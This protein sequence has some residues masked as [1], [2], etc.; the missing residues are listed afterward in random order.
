M[1]IHSE[2]SIIRNKTNDDEACDQQLEVE[3][4][5]PICTFGKV[6]NG[7][8]QFTIE[9]LDEAIV[10]TAV[11][12]GMASESSDDTYYIDWNMHV[13]ISSLTSLSNNNGNENENE[14]F[15]W[16]KFTKCVWPKTDDN[17]Y[18]IK[19]PLYLQSYYVL[20]KIQVQHKKKLHYISQR[21]KIHRIKIESFLIHPK[22]EVGELIQYRVKNAAYVQD[23]RI[24]QILKND[25]SGFEYEIE[26][27]YNY[28]GDGKNKYK[29]NRN[30]I[31]QDSKYLEY[32]I[33][34]CV[35]L[36][37]NWMNKHRFNAECDLILQTR[38]KELRNYYW[39]LR[40]IIASI[41][42]ITFN[43]DSQ[44]T[45]AYLYNFEFIGALL[46]QIITNYLYFDEMY[47]NKRDKDSIINYK[48][49]CFITLSHPRRTNDGYDVGYMFMQNQ[50][51]MQIDHAIAVIQQGRDHASLQGFNSSGWSCDLCRCTINVN[52]WMYHCISRRSEASDT[53]GHAYCLQCTYSMTNGI[54]AFENSLQKIIH[55]YVDQQ[56]TM[57]CIKVIVGFTVGSAVIVYI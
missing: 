51:K 33:D 42:P 25:E 50:W 6:I 3:P 5:A 15:Q 24:I 7:M 19:V 18:F 49:R 14:K 4:T 47:G 53:E 22:L 39:N 11:A 44:S 16:Q 54:A 30:D 13:F 31:F 48:A 9:N 28:S 20:V 38:N 12:F 45:G 55:Q 52:D 46:S 2:P 36:D 27:E 41:I 8:V 29:V 17:K 23:A 32:I 35:I 34:T 37:E 56:F 43:V 21:S 10:D 57:D 40:N 1:D 26:D